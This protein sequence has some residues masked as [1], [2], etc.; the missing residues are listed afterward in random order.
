MTDIHEF[1]HRQS[2]SSSSQSPPIPLLPCHLHISP[3]SGEPPIFRTPIVDT[4]SHKAQWSLV[5]TVDISERLHAHLGD[6]RHYYDGLDD[7]KHEWPIVL[8]YC[9]LTSAHILSLIASGIG[10]TQHQFRVN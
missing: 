8:N 10:M 9:G 5:K 1:Q 4:I 6:N 2:S 3:S 7:Y